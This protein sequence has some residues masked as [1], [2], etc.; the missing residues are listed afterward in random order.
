MHFKTLD[1]CA[2]VLVHSSHSGLGTS[3]LYF[4]GPKQYLG[5]RNF[6]HNNNVGKAVH[7]L[8][9]Q[10]S[11]LCKQVLEEQLVK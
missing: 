8:F 9:E 2:Q 10:Q 5:G 7:K 11:K 6:M 4:F 3:N 1:L